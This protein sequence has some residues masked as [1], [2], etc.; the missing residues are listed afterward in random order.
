MLAEIDL[1]DMGVT[2]I[3][4][5][6]DNVASSLPFLRYVRMARSLFTSVRSVLRL[7]ECLPGLKVIDASRNR[8]GDDDVDGDM[9]EDMEADL[10]SRPNAFTPLIPNDCVTSWRSIYLL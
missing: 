4:A 6:G 1:S 7:M 10:E 8:L 5:V 9:G 2:V 3:Y